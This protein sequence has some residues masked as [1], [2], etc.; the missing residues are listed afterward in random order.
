[1]T[2][3]K[4][5][6]MEDFNLLKSPATVVD[7]VQENGRTIVIL[8]QTIF[9]PQGGGQPYDKGVIIGPLGR[10]LV[11]EVRFVDGI[12]KHIGSFE[13]G[14]F[15]TGDSVQCEIDVP[16]RY[17]NS[18]LH[19][20]GHLVDMAIH[21]LGL[22]WKPGKAYHFPDGPYVE[23]S[24]SMQGW[25]KEELKKKIQEEAQ[26]LI[27]K[28]A[29]VKLLFMSK[30]EMANLCHSVPENLPEGKPARVVMYGDFGIPCGG[31]HVNNIRDIGGIIVRNIKVSK[32]SQDGEEIIKVGYDVPR[33]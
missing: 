12:V 3:T 21:A 18:R 24:G 6:Y 23:Y 15:K 11:A 5:M 28:G 2:P 32:G 7:V 22:N 16:R 20:G 33:D 8:D 14:E 27:E 29:E 13:M 10:F 26:K 25:D 9:Y 31:T 17:L 1:M 30:Q 19:A 4:L